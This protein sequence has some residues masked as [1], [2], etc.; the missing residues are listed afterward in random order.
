MEERQ[1]CPT[2]DA[3]QMLTK[4]WTVLLVKQLLEG[5]QRFSEMESSLQISGRIL[6]ERLRELELEELIKRHVYPD[7]PVRVEYVLTDK[8]RAMKPIILEIEIWAKE[9]VKQRSDGSPSACP[10]ADSSCSGVD[11]L[12]KE[13]A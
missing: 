13:E 5:P 4:R 10:G 9:W 12:C 7:I 3:T 8:G 1:Y 6:S 11:E 2:L